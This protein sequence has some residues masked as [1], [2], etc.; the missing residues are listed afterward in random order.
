MKI[1]RAEIEAI[2]RPVI[3]LNMAS[4]LRPIIFSIFTDESSRIPIVKTAKNS[5]AQSI[6]FKVR[7]L[8]SLAITNKIP[9]LPGPTVTGIDSGTTD[10]SSS[11]LF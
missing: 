5:P 9:I 2:N 8:F 7:G 4:P 3:L 11:L 6:S 10:I 1:N